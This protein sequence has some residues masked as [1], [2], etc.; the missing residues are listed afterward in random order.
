MNKKAIFMPLLSFFVLSILIYSYY[1]L[2]VKE[3]P[4]QYKD[5]GI[6]QAEIIKAYNKGMEYEFNAENAVNYAS[7]I[8]INN[9]S[10]NGG[11]QANCGG[12]WKFN[13]NCEPDLEK[14]FIE[15]FNSALTNYS[16]TAK[17]IKIENNTIIIILDFNYKK[18]SKNFK[19][20][21]NL[22][23][24]I[25]QDLAIDFNKLNLLKERIKDCARKGE[26]L[27]ICS[28]EKNKVQGDIVTFTI[29]NNKNIVIYTDKLETK[30]SDFV[31]KIDTQDTGFITKLQL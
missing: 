12:K 1:E 30:K 26:D 5:I 22:P 8:A 3:H 4:D 18:E 13:S 6:N 25:K 7:Y 16:Y 11:V 20:E 31:F 2:V 14:N 21:Y 19:L 17:D 9:F 23:I 10:K 15:I 28:N 29:E 27:N 24:T